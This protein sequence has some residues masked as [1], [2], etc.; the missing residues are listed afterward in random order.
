MS[1][2]LNFRPETWSKSFIGQ[3]LKSMQK[4]GAADFFK[5]LILKIALIKFD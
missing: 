1:F 3:F 4:G 5:I 2:T